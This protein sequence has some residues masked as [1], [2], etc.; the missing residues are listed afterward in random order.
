MPKSASD[1]IAHYKSDGSLALRG[2]RRTWL[3]AFAQS[4]APAQ[5]RIPVLEAGESVRLAWLRVGGKI[6]TSM[7]RVGG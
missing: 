2:R 5:G 4:V 6:R 7:S 1:M 3:N